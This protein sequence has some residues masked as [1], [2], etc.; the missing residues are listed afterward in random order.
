VARPS[1]VQRERRSSANT[2]KVV[3]VSDRVKKLL[4]T[5]RGVPKEIGLREVKEAI[6]ENT[7]A[8]KRT[9]AILDE[10]Y[11][12]PEDD[13]IYMGDTQSVPASSV[14]TVTW[15]LKKDYK[16]YLKRVYVDAATDCTYQWDFNYLLGHNY[17]YTKTIEGNEHEFFKKLLAKGGSK[18][19]LTITNTSPNDYELDIVMEMWARRMA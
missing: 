6:E 18:I 10:H 14:V 13:E 9:L 17:E 16:F 7:K 8:L 12:L 5:E 15:N 1:R 11:P 19:T 4:P 3:S 2:E